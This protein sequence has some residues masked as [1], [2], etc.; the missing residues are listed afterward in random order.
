MPTL[1]KLRKV[2]IVKQ[3][4]IRKRRRKV[5]VCFY[6]TTLLFLHF[7]NKKLTL[8]RIGISLTLNTLSKFKES[9]S[10]FGCCRLNRQTAGVE[11]LVPIC[12]R[13][14]REPRARRGAGQ[15]QIDATAGG[16]TLEARPGRERDDRTV[17]HVLPAGILSLSTTIIGH[18][19]CIHN[20]AADLPLVNSSSLYVNKTFNTQQC[21]GIENSKGS[22]I[23]GSD[24][25]TLLSLNICRPNTAQKK[26][27]EVAQAKQKT[28]SLPFSLVTAAP[29]AT[30]FQRRVIREKN[31]CV[32][33]HDHASLSNHQQNGISAFIDLDMQ[34]FSK[35]PPVSQCSLAACKVATNFCG[36]QNCVLISPDIHSG[37][38]F[39]CHC[40]SLASLCS[41]C[42]EQAIIFQKNTQN[43]IF[44]FVT[45]M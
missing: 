38:P 20:H 11:A 23:S 16:R 3:G 32:F 24:F 42:L 6:V 19:W 33:W 45:R 35:Y 5:F 41:F 31:F 21:G 40:V 15:R 9:Q 30:D 39:L 25:Q 18:I 8:Q 27:H 10:F 22:L 34:W 29:A 13:N 17:R 4:T 14:P 2:R 7:G 36:T 37:S 44:V 12:V 1:Y 43:R 26:F 28:V